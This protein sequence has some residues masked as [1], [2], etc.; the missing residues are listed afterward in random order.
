MTTLERDILKQGD[1]KLSLDTKLILVIN[2]SS[3]FNF[4]LP[5][6][7]LYCIFLTHSSTTTEK[8]LHSL[9]LDYCF[10]I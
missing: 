7:K 5:S 8:I 2:S 3:Q 4:P 9:L 10:E 6:D 1:M